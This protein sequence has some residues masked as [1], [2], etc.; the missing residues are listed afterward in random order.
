MLIINF[1]Y[2]NVTPAVT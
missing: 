1:V 2:R